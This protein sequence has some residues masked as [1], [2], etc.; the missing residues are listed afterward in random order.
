[1]AKNG[2]QKKGLEWMDMAVNG[3]K[4]F[5]MIWPYWSFWDLGTMGYTNLGI[6]DWGISNWVWQNQVSW[7]SFLSILFASSVSVG[8]QDFW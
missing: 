5:E 6:G 3:C 8:M 1:M 7:S 2:L 4:W